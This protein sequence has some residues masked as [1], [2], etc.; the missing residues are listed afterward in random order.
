MIRTDWTAWGKPIP[1]RTSVACTVRRSTRPWPR[2]LVRDV[3]RTFVQRRV[4]SWAS[5]VGRFASTISR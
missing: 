1:A 5:S 3:V 4:A 2:L